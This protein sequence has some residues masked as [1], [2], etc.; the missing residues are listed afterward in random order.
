M[1]AVKTGSVACLGVLLAAAAKG[2]HPER[3]AEVSH[4]PPRSTSS[5]ATIMQRSTCCVRARLFFSATQNNSGFEVARVL[6]AA[7]VR[8]DDDADTRRCTRDII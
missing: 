5:P 4:L 7:R 2:G 1:F 8:W 3:A 6:A